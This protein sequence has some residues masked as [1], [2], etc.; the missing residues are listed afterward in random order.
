MCAAALCLS[1]CAGQLPGTQSGS[2]PVRRPAAAAAPR[3]IQTPAVVSVAPTPAPPPPPVIAPSPPTARVAL[4][5][6]IVPSPAPVPSTAYGTEPPRA[7]EPLAAAKPAVTFMVPLSSWSDL[8]DFDRRPEVSEI[9]DAAR[10]YP[11]S[12]IYLGGYVTE[13]DTRDRHV[14]A[15]TLGDDLVIQ[16][17]RKLAARGI[18]AS[19]ISGRGMGVNRTIGRAVVASFD[20]SPS[21]PLSALNPRQLA[22]RAA[23]EQAPERLPLENRTYKQVA[24]LSSYIVGPGDSLKITAYRSSGTAEFGATVNPLGTIT[25]DLIEDAP[26]AG[27]TTLEIESLLKSMLKRYYRNP[28]VSVTVAA[29]G[30]KSVTL[31]TPSGNRIVP[32][33]G[34]TTVFDL[35]VQQNIPTG[36]A[37][38]GIADLKA[39]RVTRGSKQYSVNAFQIVQDNDWKENLVLDDGDVVFMPTFTQAGDYVTVLGAV[40]KP[41]LYPLSGTL[42]ASQALFEAGGPLKTAY[43]PHARIVRGNSQ[44]PEIIPADIDL[45]IE[46][47]LRS[48]E[49]QLQSGDIV[50]VPKN[51]ITNWNEFLSD[52][53]PTLNVATLP[54]RAYYLFHIVD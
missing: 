28:R 5:P 17:A 2:E 18:D 4:E 38:P 36:A 14:D 33:G 45:V 49:K 3:K 15:A 16:A 44:H 53:L 32:L 11:E 46:Q 51:R 9:V 47:G 6:P 50:Y 12:L 29:Y 48:A 13:A 41:G 27:L 52:L 35:I 21:P 10:R 26:V 8:S 42:T 39:V 19:R 30:S 1:A 7:L 23:S 20:V 25:F 37:G 31:I 40:A 22:E 54:L 24:G 43:L 34:R